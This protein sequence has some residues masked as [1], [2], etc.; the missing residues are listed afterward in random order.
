VGTA[1]N[2]R[3][4]H[5]RALPLVSII[6]ANLNGKAHLRRCLRSIE[7]QSHSNHEIV[8]VDNGSVDGSCEFVEE[9]FPRVRIIKLDRNVGFAEASNIGASASRGEYLTFLNN[10]TEVDVNWLKE[11]VQVFKRDPSV[12][13][14]Q[15]KQMQFADRS[16]LL[17]VGGFIDR[18]GFPYA[19]GYGETDVGQYDK[20]DD[21]FFAA[22]SCL[23]A[24][25]STLDTIGLFD[26]RYFL[27]YEDVDLCWRAHLSGYRVVYVPESVY[28][29]VGYA[30]TQ[31]TP[32][33]VFHSCKNH[34]ATLIKNYELKNVFRYGGC[35]AVFVL[36]YSIL[37]VLRGR[38]DEG[39]AYATAI[40]WNLWH[41]GDTWS[42]RT[43]VQR[44]RGV[45]EELIQEFL[46][47][48]PRGSLE[49]KIRAALN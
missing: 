30:T 27:Y 26:S 32:T 21:I 11:L 18:W 20:V 38:V 22:G 25:R 35:F 34:L 44:V 31:G 13:C 14:A 23:M 17:G 7:K 5:S 24:R 3:V 19:K 15:S 2:A 6:I 46:R 16:R 48:A 37:S 47:H 40:V 41:M 42:R 10:D 8:V 29:H 9:S 1:R 49:L 39:R 4:H 33:L 45:R 12:G 28:Y 43:E 36:L